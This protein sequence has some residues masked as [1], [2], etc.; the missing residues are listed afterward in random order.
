MGRQP[1]SA[2]HCCTGPGSSSGSMTTWRQAH[3]RG[4]PL[5]RSGEGREGRPVEL[6]RDR[7]P[8]R[9]APLRTA[10]DASGGAAPG[11]RR[12]RPVQTPRCDVRSSPWPR[13]PPPMPRAVDTSPSAPTAT[14]RSHACSSARSAPTSA[15]SAGSGR[16]AA[17]TSPVVTRS[18]S[19]DRRTDQPDGLRQLGDAA[20]ADCTAGNRPGRP[21]PTRASSTSASS[22]P[23]ESPS[24]AGHDTEQQVRHTRGDERAHETAD[25]CREDRPQRHGVRPAPQD[26]RTTRPPRTSHPA[27]CPGPAPRGPWCPPWPPTRRRSRPPT[28]WPR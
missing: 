24:H 13:W 12:D 17:A 5:E 4:G 2:S 28:R 15:A 23:E 27:R 25:R 9:V 26:E 7:S 22:R 19:S 14:N 11:R 8:G 1:S 3:A 6:R 21:G 10:P 16:A 18:P 20:S